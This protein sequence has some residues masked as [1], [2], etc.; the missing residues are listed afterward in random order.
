MAK[1]ILIGEDEKAIAK[2][3]QLK[4]SSSGYEVKNAFDGEQVIDFV[5]K[6]QFD[7]I[8]LDLIMPKLDGFGTLAKLKEKG[9]KTPVIILSNLSQEEDEKK[10]KELGAKDFFI[11]SNTPLSEIVDHVKAALE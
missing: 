1:K 2:A 11:K 6:E 7:L 3:L 4:L 9:N 5:E 8:L 10:A